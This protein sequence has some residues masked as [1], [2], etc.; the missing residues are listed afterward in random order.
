MSMVSITK[1]TDEK[2]MQECCSFTMHN[3]KK[4]SMTLDKIYRCGHSPMRSQIFMIKMI[5]IPTF[6][7]VHFVRHK[8]GVEHFVMT[9][10]NDRGAIETVA[11]RNTPINHL[12]IINAEALINMAHKRLCSQA[13]EETVRWMKM[14]VDQILHLDPALHKYLVPLCVYRNGLCTELK[15]CGKIKEMMASYTS[16]LED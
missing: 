3:P 4:S 5:D 1:L 9:N 11:D 14:I 8:I 10:R 7:S 13:H 16:K 15:P 12:M 2:I 6:V